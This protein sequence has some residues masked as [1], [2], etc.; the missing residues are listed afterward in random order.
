M[1]QEEVFINGELLRLRREARGW[2]LN[3]MATRACMSVKQIRQLEEGGMSSFYSVAVKVTAAKK[4]G[5]LLGLSAEEV[6]AQTAEPAIVEES[7]E[8]EALIAEVVV[9]PVATSLAVD[10]PVVSAKVDTKPEL[11]EPV[12]AEL[13][14]AS[15]S[16]DETPNSKNSLWL[17]A[18]LL[19]LAL[20]LAAYFRPQEEPVTEPAPP[21][22]VL[23]ADVVD[24]ASAA[25]AADAPASAAEVVV[26]PA[27]AASVSAPVAQK[28][29]STPVMNS[30]AVVP[31]ASA[32]RVVV[33][34]ASGAS[35]MRAASSPVIAAPSAAS[36][37][38]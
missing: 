36:K 3:D 32:A 28:P 33:P 10:A 17:I 19:G 16:K 24:P 26:A 18:A 29:A 11:I 38:P 15:E 37:A 34:A 30:P 23:P 21:I 12:T 31:V 6:F 4:V 9:E 5:A 13:P 35:V 8:P 14:H 7:I 20:A 22:Q 2:V 25:S 1:S 27:S